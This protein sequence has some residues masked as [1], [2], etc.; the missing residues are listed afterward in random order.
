LLGGG[1]K[2]AGWNRDNMPTNRLAIIPDM[3]HY[4]AFA[5]TRVAETV[6]PFLDH[7]SGV[8]SSAAHV[9]GQPPKN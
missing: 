1:L 9:K 6:L 7:Q 5:S 4:E 2:A 3:T 8:K